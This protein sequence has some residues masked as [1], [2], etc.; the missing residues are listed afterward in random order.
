VTVVCASC[1]GGRL[2]TLPRE[3]LFSLAL[4]SME[5]QIDLFM[6]AGKPLKKRNL[7][8]LKGGRIYIVNG[9]AS[10]VMEL[11]PYG[12]L[13]SL[14]YNPDTNPMPVI[15][16]TPAPGADEPNRVAQAYPLSDPGVMA[17]D[18]EKRLYIEDRVGPLQGRFDEST[19]TT[20]YA[21]VLRFDRSGKLV[22]YLGQEGVK[23]T[24]FPFVDAIRM[25]AHDE[26]V[27]VCR[28][29]PAR[30]IVYWF[31]RE[32]SLLYRVEFDR[33]YLP[34]TDKGTAEEK[35]RTVA[36]LEN[37][38]ADADRR[39][40]LLAV[41]YYREE[42]NTSTRTPETWLHVSS[43]IHRF[44]L[45]RAQYVGRVDV[46]DAGTRREQVGATEVEIPSAPYEFLGNTRNGYLYFLKPEQA[47]T[48]QLL[49]L[50][51]RGREHARRLITVEERE[52]VFKKMFLSE[53]GVLVALLGLEDGAR[54]A[55]WRSDRLAEGPANARR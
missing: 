33:D 7:I 15:L 50:D 23:G 25:T 39:E 24:P 17:V 12:D 34:A 19:G 51:S 2:P 31:T 45:A 13:V 21:H 1:T 32:G 49:V 55:W 6:I 4:G 53:E 42:M 14:L 40:L 10:K 35:Q 9:S 43:R 16:K 48:Y 22:D 38:Y 37:I 29:P 36:S 8:Y 30:W 26:A 11:S 28:V 47:D 52:L 54:V 44:D 46:P 3:E 27:V 41:S 20:H 5:N 18:G